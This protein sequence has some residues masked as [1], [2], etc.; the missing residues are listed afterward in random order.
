MVLSLFQ[1][2]VKNSKNY[3]PAQEVV[4]KANFAL[5]VARIVE[6]NA[7]PDATYKMECNYMCDWVGFIILNTY[8]CTMQVLDIQMQLNSAFIFT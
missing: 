4:R 2:Q 8:K 7:R 5:Q 6:H 1:I 3:S